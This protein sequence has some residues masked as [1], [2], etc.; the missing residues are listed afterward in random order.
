MAVTCTYPALVVAL[1]S[2]GV[3]LVVLAIRP[4]LRMVLAYY[5]PAPLVRPVIHLEL[6]LL[7]LLALPV[8]PLALVPMKKKLQAVHRFALLVAPIPQKHRS[9]RQ[10]LVASMAHLRTPVRLA[11]GLIPWLVLAIPL[12]AFA[13]VLLSPSIVLMAWLLSMVF[14]SL[15]QA[16]Q[17]QLTALMEVRPSKRSH[18]VLPDVP[19][20]QKPQIHLVVRLHK[21]ISLVPH[22]LTCAKTTPR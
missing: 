20:K 16:L 4:L 10:V 19:L 15:R 12:M 7:Q 14:V 5:L 21:I 8:N 9:V 1:T 6:A 3:A 17:K 22:S 13:R 2:I 18:V 11:L